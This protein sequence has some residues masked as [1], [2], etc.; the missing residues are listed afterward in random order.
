MAILKAVAAVLALT[1]GVSAQSVKTEKSPP[2]Q[3]TCIPQ[4]P[5][6]TCKAVTLIFAV[7]QQLSSAMRQVEVVIADARSFREERERMTSTF[8]NAVKRVPCKAESLKPAFPSSMNDS[9]IFEA[10]ETGGVGKMILSADLFNRVRTIT[11]KDGSKVED[12]HEFGPETVP[13]F[14]YYIMGYVDGSR[15]ARIHTLAE[16][17]ETV[18]CK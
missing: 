6:N 1:G 2:A 7:N 16:E 13:A 12:T 17:Q 10:D 3:I 18:R 9:M 4:V 8:E 15:Y 5:S 14:A 11:S